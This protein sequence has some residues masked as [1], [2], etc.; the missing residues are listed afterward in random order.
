MK[1][2][3]QSLKYLSLS[4][5]VIVTFWS[6]LFYINM[7]D[8]IHDSIDDG[9]DNYKLLILRKAE[10][11]TTVLAKST[12]GESNY[13][14]REIRAETAR[15]IRDRYTDTLMYM[16]YEDDLEPVRMLTTAF[17]N[18]GRFYELK[19]MSSMVEE[20][21]LIED[22]F[23]SVFWLYIILVASIILLHNVVLQ[24]LWRPFYSLLQQ[25]KD[26]RL[27]SHSKLPDIH[28]QT[29]E[30][31]DLKTAV[32]TL[33]SH[34][35]ETF[36]NQK[37]FIGNASH[38]L[39]T[40]LAIATHKLELLLEKGSLTDDQAEQAGQILQIVERLVRLNKSLLLLAKIENKQYFNNQKVS[41]PEILQQGMEDLGPIAEY[42]NVQLLLEGTYPLY[43]SMD[44][45]LAGIVINNLIKN[46]IVHN[47]PGGV[48]KIRLVDQHLIVSNSGP[49]GPLNPDKIFTRFYKSDTHQK[50][51][52]LGLAIVKAICDL[53]GFHITYR[54][55]G[56]HEF[57]L[58][59]PDEKE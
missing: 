19:V 40:P 18:H 24:R 27:S 55:N 30:F 20:D 17:E 7:L 59:F 13:T 47:H 52:G 15:I 6:V 29:K 9:L 31:N 33:L 4:I 2:L 14:I 10:Q 16:P 35:I 34:S 58:F 22:L 50:N 8:E 53:Y 46:A 43:T 44:P 51:T 37:Q 11:D 41:I 21:D 45:S 42:K 12:F 38:E 48:V 26:F 49:E 36:E 57:D 32:N 1:L 28:T 5:L 23:W 3:N 56:F 39:Q 54:Y 25:L